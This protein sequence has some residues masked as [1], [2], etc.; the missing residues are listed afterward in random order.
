MTSIQHLAQYNRK[1]GEKQKKEDDA[2][3]NEYQ[4]IQK[5][6]EEAKAKREKERKAKE[7]LK[8]K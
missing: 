3:D 4:M 5:M 6:E 2:R 8:R 7:D 1:V